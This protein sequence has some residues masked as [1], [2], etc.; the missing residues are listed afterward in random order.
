VKW[1]TA[2]P[3][4]FHEHCWLSG[5]LLNA[6]EL[7]KNDW[8]QSVQ[9]RYGSWRLG[10]GR[11]RERYAL[12]LNKE[13][14]ATKSTVPTPAVYMAQNTC[15]TSHWILV[16]MVGNEQSH[17]STCPQNTI[18]LPKTETSGLLSRGSRQVG[19]ELDGSCVD[20]SVRKGRREMGFKR[21]AAPPLHHALASFA[22]PCP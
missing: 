15:N 10:K 18:C 9:V 2:N 16:I 7:A 14:R 4:K 3:V 12:G 17:Q 13:L 21:C 8:N 5:S 1:A 20:F 19:T 22:P 6:Y 11:S